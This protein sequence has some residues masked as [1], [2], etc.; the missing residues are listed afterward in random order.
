MDSLSFIFLAHPGMSL[1]C[2]L[3][4][5]SVCIFNSVCVCMCVCIYIY[6][7]VCVYIYI[8]VCIYIY[9]TCHVHLNL[10]VS[11][12]TNFWWG[13]QVM[14]TSVTT[15]ETVRNLWL[16]TFL[17]WDNDDCLNC[18]SYYLR[19]YFDIIFLEVAISNHNSTSWWV[20]LDSVTQ[21]KT[22]G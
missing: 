1:Q 4:N 5:I 17:K 21:R 18:R 22:S 2:L 19:L 12:T 11:Y 8:Y 9:V 20:L 6:M 10:L 7:C 13:F 3:S 15:E 14:E 16:L